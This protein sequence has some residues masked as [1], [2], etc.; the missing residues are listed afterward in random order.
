MTVQVTTTPR[1]LDLEDIKRLAHAN[2]PC[3]TIHIPDSHPGSAEAPRRIQLRQLAHSALE[4]LGNMSRTP[5]A[6]PVAAALGKF[7]ETIDMGGGPGYTVFVAPGHEMVFSTPGVDAGVFA[8]GNFHLLPLI[9]KAAAPKD[10]YA[11]GLSRKSVRLWHV[12][13][14]DCEEVALPHTVPANIEAAAGDHSRHNLQN[15]STVGAN[16]GKMNSMRFGT[17]SDYDSEAEY[18]AHF[19]GMVAKGLYDVVRD[20]PVF[21]IG[22][23]PDTLAYRKVAHGANVFEAEWQE[24]PAVCTTAQVDVEARAAAANET[25]RKSEVAVHALPEMRNKIVND[26]V[27]TQR[28]AAEG[29]VRDLFIAE[30]ARLTEGDSRPTR[31]E[32]LNAAVVQAFRTGAAVHILNGETL[33][34]GGT[35]AAVLRY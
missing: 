11:L 16:A 28:A 20:A 9:A 27:A 33:P 23:R 22:T 12:T 4:M 21:L 30:K 29:R 7:V 19:F 25:Y 34:G 13:P 5:G 6:P 24:N 15:R 26:P 2:G 17:V 35:V 3:V 18:L 1:Q 14:E 10:Y 32:A 31:D 8:G